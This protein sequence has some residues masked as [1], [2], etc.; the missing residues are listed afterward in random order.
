V[1]TADASLLGDRYLLTEVIGRGG[2]ADVHR[3]T[4]RVLDREV[5]VKVLRDRAADPADRARFTGEARTLAAL[6]HSGLVMILDAGIDAEQPYLVMELVEGPTL[7]RLCAG[8]PIAPAEVARIGAQVATA[9]AYA[10]GEGV[11]H[12]DVKPGNVLMGAAGRVKLADFG[13]ARLI[14]DTM[15]H[16]KTGQAIGTAA[17]LAPEQVRG[18]DVTPAADV[19]SLGLVLLEA[20]TG[21]RAY[22]GPPTEAA[23]AR[24][25][26]PPSIPDW[27]PEDWRTL[28]AGATASEPA[29]RPDAAEV[30]GRLRALAPG[31]GTDLADATRV[32]PEP[33][34]QPMTQ[35]PAPVPAPAQPRVGERV[36]DWLRARPAE[37]RGVGAA[38]AAMLLLVVVAAFAAS[39]DDDEPSQPDRAPSETPPRLKA[40]L[41]DLHDAINGVDR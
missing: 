6:N 33:I 17:Y 32:M 25:S 4:D 12:R 37:Q 23:L 36:R 14:G 1:S 13:I 38:V 34:T 21:E 26:S 27:L 7:A 28:L 10:H 24:L 30:A 22:Q 11:V 40:P 3:G 5:A 35:P 31:P 41:E 20:L 15:R 18:R 8:T 29:D 2:M 19:Y 9:L 39:G 16:T